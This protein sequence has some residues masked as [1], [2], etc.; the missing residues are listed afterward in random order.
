MATIACLERLKAT[1]LLKGRNLDQLIGYLE[2]IRVGG[3]GRN[4]NEKLK[5]LGPLWK[6]FTTRVEMLRTTSKEIE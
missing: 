5:S 6:Q 2:D 1:N 4:L 3:R